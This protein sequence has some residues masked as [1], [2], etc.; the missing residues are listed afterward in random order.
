MELGGNLRSGPAITIQPAPREI[1]PRQLHI[2]LL[3]AH[4]TGISNEPIPKVMIF[5]CARLRGRLAARRRLL[6]VLFTCER[7]A[8]SV[9]CGAVYL[10]RRRISWLAPCG[11]AG[12]PVGGSIAAGAPS[13]FLDDKSRR[14]RRGRSSPRP[15]SD[16]IY[17][18]V[19]RGG[20]AKTQGLPGMRLQKEQNPRN[21]S[22]GR[23]EILI[24]KLKY[25]PDGI[26]PG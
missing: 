26:G 20:A 2:T 6:S 3:P 11:L 15:H 12:R 18:T 10:R 21:L 14:I 23:N 7:D 5:A 8:G 17:L 9:P 24:R 16:G 4:A 1:R 25:Y 19:G 22:L 13:A